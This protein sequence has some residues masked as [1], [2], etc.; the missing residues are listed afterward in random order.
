L[1]H[2]DWEVILQVSGRSVMVTKFP[3]WQR[4]LYPT[5]GF[6]ALLGPFIVFCF[7]KERVHYLAA[8][9]F[10]VAGLFAMV[11]EGESRVKL[12]EENLLSKDKDLTVEQKLSIASLFAAIV[13]AIYSGQTFFFGLFIFLISFNTFISSFSLIKRYQ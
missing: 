9:F 11:H 10:A 4:V 8:A 12:A 1:S 3:L 2:D 7:D 5:V 13:V 6:M